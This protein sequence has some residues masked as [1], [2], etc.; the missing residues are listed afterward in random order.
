MGWSITNCV[1]RHQDRL[2]QSFEEPPLAAHLVSPRRFYTHHGIYVGRG[3]VIHYAGFSSGFHR[4]PVEEVSLEE[5]GKGRIVCVRTDPRA[6]PPRRK[7]LSSAYQQLSALLQLVPARPDARFSRLSE[8][9][10]DGQIIGGVPLGPPV[11][12]RPLTAPSRQ[13]NCRVAISCSDWVPPKC[14]TAWVYFKAAAPA[15]SRGLTL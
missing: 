12:D 13:F 15:R 11:A 14:A 3:R 1:S 10:S 6:C 5:F 7:R 4:G 8:T 9:P 2:L